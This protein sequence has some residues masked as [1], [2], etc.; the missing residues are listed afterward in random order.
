MILNLVVSMK[1]LL[2]QAL[3]AYSPSNQLAL[4]RSEV[5]S[6]LSREIPRIYTSAFNIIGKFS[7]WNAENKEIM[8]NNLLGLLPT[9]GAMF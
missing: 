4:R 8:V 5:S 2:S 1:D 7:E 6:R 3:L 9:Y